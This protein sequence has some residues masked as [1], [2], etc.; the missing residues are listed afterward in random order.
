MHAPCNFLPQYFSMDLTETQID[1]V[2]AYD[3]D[4]LKVRK[5]HARMPDGSASSREYIS[6]PGSVAILAL[7]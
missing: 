3:G 5:D 1:S 4:F 7:L 6:H 2:L